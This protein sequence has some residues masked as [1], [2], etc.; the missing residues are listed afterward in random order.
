MVDTS[1]SHPARIVDWPAAGTF[2]EAARLRDLLLKEAGHGYMVI[3]TPD[4]FRVTRTLPADQQAMALPSHPPVAP[5]TLRPA[6]RNGWLLGVFTTLSLAGIIMAD[7]LTVRMLMYFLG[8]DGT[9]R[10]ISSLPFDP[11]WIMISICLLIGAGSLVQ[12]IYQRYVRTYRI[13]SDAVEECVGIIARAT[14]KVQLQHVRSVGLR[15]SIVGRLFGIGDLEFASAG[16]GE[17]DIRFQGIRHPA[18]IRQTIQQLMNQA[19][20]HGNSR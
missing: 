16:T 15:Q 11:S 2:A 20:Q 5:L 8:R 6:W 19:S 17:I 12:W 18:R 1:S 3:E 9:A 13:T 4:G 7:E 10:L 14:R